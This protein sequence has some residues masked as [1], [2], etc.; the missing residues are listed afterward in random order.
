MKPLELNQL[1]R[2][3]KRVAE[4]LCGESGRMIKNEEH[5]L[6]EF[7][8]EKWGGLLTKWENAPC[9]VND[10]RNWE[11]PPDFLHAC[12]VKNRLM[13]MSTSESFDYY[14]NLIEQALLD[15]CSRHLVEIGCGY[16]S[17]LFNLIGRRRLTYESV[18]GLEYTQQ[19]IELAQNLAKWHDYDVTI[20]KGDFG[21]R[22]ISDLA[23]KPGSDFL[24]S[25]ALHYMR[26][27]ALAL[28]NLIRLKPRRV[29]HFEP[30][31]QHCDEQTVL[32]IL[33]QRYMRINDYNLS[34][35]KELEKLA[36]S[37]EIEIIK[38]IPVIF[39]ANCLLPAS[40]LVWSPTS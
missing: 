19:G 8:Q 31:F 3:S 16:G 30:I 15:G 9:G 40:L 5:I 34:I 33:Q 11:C 24:T 4:L 6:R 23:I 1:P 37:G 17:V 25:Y 18:T 32:G 28:R 21:A 38:E 12:L 22:N 7:G 29:L 26:D 20:G 39:G 10:V 27:S 14:I 2:Y 35:R 36:N 13:L